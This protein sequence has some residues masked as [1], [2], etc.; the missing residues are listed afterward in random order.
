MSTKPRIYVAFRPSLYDV[1]FLPETDLALRELGEVTF[2]DSEVNLSSEELALRIA[3]VDAVLTSWGAPRFTPQVL[4]AADRLK[5]VAHAAGS[6][7]S[8][9]PPAVFEKGIAVTHAAAAIAGAVADLSLAFTMLLLRRVHLHD[10][11][12]RAGDWHSAKELGLGHELEG[13]R[14]GVVGAGYTG[15][16]FIKLLRA[17][18]A[19]VWVYDPYVSA[20]RAAEL[21]VTV[22]GLD[23]LFAQCPVVSV[24]APATEETRHMI[25]AKQLGLLQDGACFVNTARSWV[26]DYDALLAE[27]QTGRIQAA[28]DVFEREPLPDD[29]P[30]R[31][32][33]NVIMTPHIAGASVEARHRQGQ[34]MVEELQRFFT[35]QPLRY[36]VTIDMLETMA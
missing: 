28:L 21:G 19:E 16:C 26:I 11:F 17:L 27:L 33:D 31:K 3:G 35:G 13:T 6:I 7:R 8:L 23:Q 25:G 29:N 12:L 2:H 22:V 36:Q 30:F 1:L 10:R 34:W 9:L 20:G 32:L 24:Q 18:D 15:R 5:V 14:V 4:D